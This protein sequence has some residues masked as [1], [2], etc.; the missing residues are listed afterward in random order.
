MGDYPLPAVFELPLNLNELGSADGGVEHKAH[1]SIG[2]DDDDI[3]N[4]PD[5]VLGYS[6]EPK[7]FAGDVSVARTAGRT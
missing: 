6:C 7:Y 1:Y 5:R 4:K 3:G 2:N